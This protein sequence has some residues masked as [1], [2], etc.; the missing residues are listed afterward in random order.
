MDFKFDEAL[1]R[2]MFE[3]SEGTALAI[4]RRTVTGHTGERHSGITNSGLY[5]RNNDVLATAF[6]SFKQAIG[7]AVKVLN[8]IPPQQLEAVYYAQSGSN[9]AK[10]SFTID[11]GE[12]QEVRYGRNRGTL[13]CSHFTIVLAKNP[14]I[15]GGL[16]VIT[17][18][19]EGR[20][21][22]EK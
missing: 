9:A 21:M 8:R 14:T 2:R 10:R 19:P 6:V 15:P 7:I 18:Y 16:M 3:G 12:K 13:L 4:G 11:I 1:V 22:E 5:D 20:F 17:F